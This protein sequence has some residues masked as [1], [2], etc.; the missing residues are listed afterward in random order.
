MLLIKKDFLADGTMKHVFFFVKPAIEGHFEGTLVG[1]LKLMTISLIYFYTSRILHCQ[2]EQLIFLKL[3]TFSQ[4]GS[5]H[6]YEDSQQSNK[7]INVLLKKLIRTKTKVF[8][9]LSQRSNKFINAF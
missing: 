5:K 4:I 7:F 2:F 1:P 9:L 6:Q 3:F 8:L